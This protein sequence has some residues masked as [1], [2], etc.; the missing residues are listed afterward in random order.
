M[1]VIVQNV[2]SY[3]EIEIQQIINNGIDIDNFH[4][5]ITMPGGK[6]EAIKYNFIIDFPF[7]FNIND[8][9][10][11]IK[12]SN[13]SI[14]P[15]CTTN[16]NFVEFFPVNKKEESLGESVLIQNIPNYV[17]FEKYVIIQYRSKNNPKILC[18]TTNP[19]ID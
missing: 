18:I 9:L 17:L 16:N 6:V 14:T 3:D 15:L 2:K 19:F 7:D 11:N 5:E 1:E 12:I 8:F 13:N 4:I 10:C